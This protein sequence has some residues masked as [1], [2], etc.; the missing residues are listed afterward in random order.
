MWMQSCFWAV[1]VITG[2]S[3]L[4]SRGI[5]VDPSTAGAGVLSN[6]EV[7]CCLTLIVLGT[8]LWAYVLATFVDVITNIDP[9]E[10]Q[11]LIDQ[12]RLATDDLLVVADLARSREF[13]RFDDRQAR[14][15]AAA[16]CAGILLRT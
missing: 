9:E 2:I 4:P 14:R 10:M 13:A 1:S 8:M 11:E 15:G 5:R 7:G 3:Y 16:A 6:E 12:F